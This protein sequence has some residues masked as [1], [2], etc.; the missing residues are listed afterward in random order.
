[1]AALPAIEA[2]PTWWS[3]NRQTV[4]WA[5][6]AVVFFM[7]LASISLGGSFARATYTFVFFALCSSP[8]LLLKQFN[9]RYA[10]L[11]VFMAIYFVFFGMLDLLSLLKGAEELHSDRFTAGE[12]GILAG[13]I[14]LLLSY[15]AAANLGAPRV[16]GSADFSRR[17]LGVVGTALWLIG[18]ASFIY[19]QV[20]VLTDKSNLAGARGLASMGQTQTF[21]VLL[22]NLLQ[23]LGVLLLAYGY[24][25]FRTISWTVLV[26]AAVATQVCMGFLADIKSAAMTGGILVIVTKTLVDN[27][28]PKVWLM[29]S[30]IFIMIAFPVF[31]AY[32]AE[33]TGERGLS[34]T[35][36]AME[37][38]RVLEIVWGARE[39]VE[40][41]R[42]EG[43]SASFFE[44]SSLKGNVELAFDKTGVEVPF[45][46]GRT[47]IDLPFAFIPRI[48]WP[49]KPG[50]P[51][52]QVFNKQFFHGSDDTYI[53]PSHLGE[54]YWNFGWWGV[55]FGMATIG[56]ILGVI[57]A[58]TDLSRGISLTRLLVLVVTIKGVCMQFEGTI[59]I[60]Y[61][62]WL[63]SL[64]AVGVLHLMFA[65]LAL[66]GVEAEAK[67][68]ADSHTHSPAPRA[69]R[70]PNF[71]RS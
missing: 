35:Q 69:V 36:A 21:F 28:L 8:L 44:R 18:S 48:I 17:T 2:Q 34:R 19:F 39:K 25:R 22:A 43:R 56:M 14:L 55:I 1:M 41:I 20:F 37:I 10:L 7:A 51:A 45:Q 29:S 62:V 65:R 71:L 52:G 31:Q 58:R 54:L 27:R 47:L 53:S 49:E 46:N 66:P 5:A 16:M 11:A 32:R 38:G 23:P 59:A 15:W 57:G 3:R 40:N 60:A 24:A 50:V 67:A 63:R 26:V 13:G 33:I 68:A 30:A 9:G 42:G 70:Y 64:A 61:V 12:I 6:N 4:Y